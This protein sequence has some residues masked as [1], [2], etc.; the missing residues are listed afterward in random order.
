MRH[1]S[2]VAGET[3]PCSD[4][5]SPGSGDVAGSYLEV[6]RIASRRCLGW[7]GNGLGL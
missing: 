2:V 4:V 1:A 5:G 3:R 6:G 7:M